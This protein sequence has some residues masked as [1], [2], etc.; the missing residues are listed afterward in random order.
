MAVW[1]DDG[2]DPVHAVASEFARIRSVRVPID[3]D[4]MKGAS[5]GACT[6]LFQSFNR[7]LDRR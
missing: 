6:V 2:Q 3:R 7:I 4:L 5:D 1:T